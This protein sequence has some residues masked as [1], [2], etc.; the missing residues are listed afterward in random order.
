MLDRI[1][2]MQVFSKVAA[3]GSFSA[4][5]RTLGISPT[6]ATKHVDAIEDRLG[7]RLL[8]RSTRKLTLTEAGQRYL[9]AAERILAEVEEADAAAAADVIEP[10]GTLR[11]NAPLSFG[12]RE[13]MP[14]I[15]DFA[16]LYPAL[17]TE[18]GLTDRF[19]D[20]IEEGWDLAI[21]IGALRDSNL[22]ARR[23]A[24]IRIALCASPAYLAENGSP[25]TVAELARHNCLGYTLPTPATAGRW[26]FGADGS[27]AVSVHGNLSVNNGD[28]LRIAALAGQGLIYQPTFILADDLRAGR[29]VA[30]ELDQPPFRFGAAYAVYAGSRRLPAKV[31]TFVD[32]L[33][34]RWTGAPWDAGLKLPLD[35]SG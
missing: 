12:F 16:R 21:R 17:A 20:L 33:A 9:D 14:V 13:V 32:F 22:I 1:T 35:E 10:R 30:L 31:R 18:V 6:M 28:A 4:A 15:A 26:L 19:V 8:F 5:A 7:A 29:L 23:L 34:A 3:M 11:I 27:V 25:K 24:P 2:G